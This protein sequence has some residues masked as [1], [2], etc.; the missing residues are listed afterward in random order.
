LP[1]VVLPVAVSAIGVS[2]SFDSQSGDSLIVAPPM[3]AATGG[4]SALPPFISAFVLN[5]P[6]PVGGGFE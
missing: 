4:R 1:G 2:P 3:E 6:D 5:F